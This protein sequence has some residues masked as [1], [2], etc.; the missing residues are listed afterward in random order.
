[1]VVVVGVSS[2]PVVIVGWSGVVGSVVWVVV[3]GGVVAVGVA[4]VGVVAVGIGPISSIILNG[5]EST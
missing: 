4:G 2:L 1:M 3:R 5:K